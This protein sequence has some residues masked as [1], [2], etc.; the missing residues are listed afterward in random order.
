MWV[1]WKVGNSVGVKGVAHLKALPHKI[2]QG[3]SYLDVSNCKLDSK[4]LDLLSSVV[5][6]MTKLK[7]LNIGDNP[8]GHG[9][10]VTLLRALSE[11]KRL[12]SLNMH[13]TESGPSDIASLSPLIQHSA[14]ILK[15][16]SIGDNEMPAED[17]EMMLET[18]LS[19]S[20]L[21]HLELRYVDLS[22]SSIASLLKHNHNLLTLTLFVCKY[23]GE[24]VTST[25]KALCSQTALRE[26]KLWCQDTTDRD[27]K[28]LSE[29]IAINQ[30]LRK[31]QLRI[32]RLSTVS[33]EAVQALVGALKKN[34]GLKQLLIHSPVCHNYFS[35]SELNDLDPRV[36][37]VKC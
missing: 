35:D 10:T 25:A 32:H 5:P 18:V 2:L 4:A 31:L 15:E 33:R 13:L 29:M 28:A 24:V 34:Q 16:L 11:A 19:P 6:I 20:S 22:S 9:G 37:L 36:K 17:V 27:V 21:E 23:K 26:F 7:E 8:A 3:M 30:T 14:G 12:H 1:Y